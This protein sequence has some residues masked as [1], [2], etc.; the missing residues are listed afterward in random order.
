MYKYCFF[1]LLPKET[2]RIESALTVVCLHELFKIS[3]HFYRVQI[4][5]TTDSC[6]IV[7]PI[8]KRL[9]QVC[10]GLEA[11]LEIEM[12]SEGENKKETTF[13]FYQQEVACDFIS[14]HH[15]KVSRDATTYILKVSKPRVCTGHII[16]C[17]L[18]LKVIQ[19][20][21]LLTVC[22]SKRS[23]NGTRT[24]QRLGTSNVRTTS[25]QLHSHLKCWMV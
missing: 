16:V 6:I 17:S 18:K 13:E 22:T 11:E 20:K 23:T 14:Y 21:N 10:D 19:A 7:K 12:K 2:K 8:L 9:G 15:A 3:S 5:V 24:R 4:G 25:R 1:L